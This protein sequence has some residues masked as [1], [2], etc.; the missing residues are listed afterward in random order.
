[1]RDPE[2]IK[3]FL[4]KVEEYWNLEPDLRFGQIVAILENRIR[5]SNLKIKESDLFFSEEDELVKVFN[6]LIDEYKKLK[7]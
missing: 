7:N 6:E 2:R 3:P 1:M 5:P 4:Q